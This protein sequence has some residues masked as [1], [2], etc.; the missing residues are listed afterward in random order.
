MANHLK[1]ITQFFE[2]N[3]NKNKPIDQACQTQ[4]AVRA[5][6]SVLV[7]KI[8]ITG[9]RWQNVHDSSLF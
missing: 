4:I 7:A 3:P 8:L 5:A 2:I 1:G 6:K 9:R